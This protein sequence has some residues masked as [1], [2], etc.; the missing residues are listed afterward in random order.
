MGTFNN[1]A[2]TGGLSDFDL[3]IGADTNDARK[4]SRALAKAGR[5][6]LDGHLAEALAQS[7]NLL[8][9][10][11][12]AGLSVR[13]IRHREQAFGGRLAA[14][15]ANANV[16]VDMAGLPEAAR[17]MHQVARRIDHLEDRIEHAVRK[18]AHDGTAQRER[19]RNRD[20]ANRG[21]TR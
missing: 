13:Q 7:E 5:K 11:Q 6:G 18:G 14:Q 2:F 19:D 10:Q 20:A 4:M 15:R 1:D 12:V 9:A 3:Q 16:A 17:A 21:R 8:L